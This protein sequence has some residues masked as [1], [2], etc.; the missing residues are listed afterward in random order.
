MARSYVAAFS[1]AGQIG[2]V[3]DGVGAENYES[4]INEKEKNATALLG[5]CHKACWV[6]VP[7]PTG[8]L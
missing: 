5:R 6:S 3:F 2:V 8:L 4:L 1:C 7:R